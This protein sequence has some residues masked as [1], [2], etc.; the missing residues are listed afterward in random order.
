MS[1]PNQNND[2]KKDP[3]LEKNMMETVTDVVDGV[4]N[5]AIRMVHGKEAA[6]EEK[7]QTEERAEGRRA[8]QAQK[9]EAEK[10]K[11]HDKKNTAGK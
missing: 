8:Y 5:F 10:N 6:E 3:R 11:A 7:R 4:H 9:Q 1:A 2:G